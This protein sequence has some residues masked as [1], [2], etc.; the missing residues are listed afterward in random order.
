[1]T[2]QKDTLLRA[3]SGRRR[4]SSILSPRFGWRRKMPFLT[5]AGGCVSL[6]GRACLKPASGSHTWWIPAS[7]STP[8]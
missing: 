4:K 7:G 8:P 3:T 6:S 2:G 5:P 1:M